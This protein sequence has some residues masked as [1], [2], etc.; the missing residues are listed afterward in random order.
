M[1]DQLHQ[2]DPAQ[3]EIYRRCASTEDL[4][5]RLSKQD[6]SQEQ[7]HC[8]AILCGWQPQSNYSEGYF[9]TGAGR[10]GTQAS[11]QDKRQWQKA[12]LQLQPLFCSDCHLRRM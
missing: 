7:R 9:L 6:K 2:Q 10:A 8:S 11:G 4:H 1:V 3:L 12:L 5:H